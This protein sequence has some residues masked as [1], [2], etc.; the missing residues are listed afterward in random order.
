[1]FRHPILFNFVFALT[2]IGLSLAAAPVSAASCQAQHTV[3]SG[4]NLYRIGLK[5]GVD[6]LSIAKVNN[7]ANPDRIYAGQVLCIPAATTATLA[8][9]S[10]PA[11]I[12]MFTI[13][14][15]VADQSVTIQAAD[16]PAHQ[17][18]EV[19]MGA[20]G[21]LGVNVVKVATADSGNGGSFTATYTIPAALQGPA[22]IAIRLQSVSGYYSYN[23]FYNNT[24]R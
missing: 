14:G 16:F 15:V 5:Y 24:T 10:K 19:L 9:T 18:F 12:P 7:L 21:T 13:A 3:K 4:E 17:Q 8:P 23:W 1:M 6:W 2:L 11:T 20:Y 22:R